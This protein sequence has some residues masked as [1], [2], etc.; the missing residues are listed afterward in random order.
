MCD[1]QTKANEELSK[2]QRQVEDQESR[3]QTMLTTIS[4]NRARMEG[5]EK[6]NK[7]LDDQCSLWRAKVRH[8]HR[9]L[10][11]PEFAKS[12]K[13]QKEKE[14]WLKQKALD[15][16][17]GARA[18]TIP[19]CCN[20]SSQAHSVA[21]LANAGI[22]IID[23]RLDPSRA[24]FDDTLNQDVTVVFDGTSEYEKEHNNSL[25]L[26]LLNCKD[27]EKVTHTL[28]HSM[29]EV[30]VSASPSHSPTALGPVGDHA[31]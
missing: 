11:M 24:G 28:I 8:R 2:A 30:R 18:G 4:G 9:A 29:A 6:K 3:I 5:L 12:K 16:S 25:G 1:K 13:G 26:G 20:A 17:L 31:I 10:E 23:R 14:E 7:E 21:T 22:C 27:R 19:A 15:D